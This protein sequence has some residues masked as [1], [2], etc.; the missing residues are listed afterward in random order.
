MKNP[1][2]ECLVKANC[3]A[4]CSEKTNYKVL[5]RNAIL[6]NRTTLMGRDV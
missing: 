2:E 5:I 6:N 1:C 3:T 4:I